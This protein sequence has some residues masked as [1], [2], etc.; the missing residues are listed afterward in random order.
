MAIDTAVAE[1]VG[2]VAEVP[3]AASGADSDWGKMSEAE[4]A[5][6]FDQALS[7]VQERRG[8]E[9]PA[10]KIAKEPVKE[11]EKTI[12]TPAGGDETPA[13]DDAALADKKVED[14]G[15]V[16]DAEVAV[17]TDWLDDD[18][19]EFATAMGLDADILDAMPNREVLDRVL[20]AIDKK[21]YEE[22]KQLQADQQQ[23]VKPIVKPAEQQPVQQTGDPLADLVSFD[24][25]EELGADDAPKIKKAF[26]ATTSIIKD[27]Q[28]RVAQFE[29]RVVQLD[30]AELTRIA[31]LNDQKFFNNLHLL[32]HTELFGK[33]GEKPNAEQAK[34][35]DKARDTFYSI[36]IGLLRSGR[37]HA[38][39]LPY[40]KAAVYHAFGDQ[41]YKQQQKQLT[42]KLRKQSA[43]RTG[44]VATKPLPQA[45]PENET[46]AQRVQR[47]AAEIEADPDWKARRAELRG[48]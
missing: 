3:I 38:P 1:Q 5:K 31:E 23:P 37:P 11:P 41:L 4:R 15:E 40:V 16:K 34:N 21:A 43:R 45:I 42:E 22:G 18:T 28:N 26:T 47:I 29:Q 48:N 13:A 39:E 19:R 27:L 35:I 36:G 9:P 2:Q 46:H 32:G 24:L 14:E 10:E 7:V 8:I 20:H 33:P 44:G 17:E 6:D 25:D 30:Q 12:E